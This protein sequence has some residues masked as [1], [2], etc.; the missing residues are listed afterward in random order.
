MQVF[1]HEIDLGIEDLVKANFVS[2]ASSITQSVEKTDEVKEFIQSIASEK[3]PDLMYRNAILASTGWNKNDDV[4]DPIEMLKA[5]N[6]P[7]DKQV[8]FMH[9]E[10][11]IIGH[12]TNAFILNTSE[13]KNFFCPT[14][15]SNILGYTRSSP[16]IAKCN[17]GHEINLDLCIEAGN[18]FDIGVGFVLYKEWSSAERK[19]LISNILEQIDS[20]KWFVSM[21][22]RFPGFDYALID[23]KGNHS[24]VKRDAKSAFLSKYLR[25]YGGPGEYQGRRIGRI[26]RDFHFSGK[27][28]VDNPA[29]ERSIIFG[30]KPEN[31]TSTAILNIGE[32]DMNLEDK[33]K[34]LTSK[35]ESYE[36]QIANL[37]NSNKSIAELKDSNAKELEQ[38]KAEYKTLQDRLTEVEKVLASKVDNLSKAE[39]ENS[40]LKVKLDETEAKVKELNDSIVKAKRIG[41]LTL[42]G[43]SVEDA[44]KTFAKWSALS[45]EQFA[46][47]VT[48]HK[49]TAKKVEEKE[50]SKEDK[51]EDKTE[52]AKCGEA[53]FS[54]AEP[55]KTVASVKLDSETKNDISALSEA[56]M[57]V[58][59]FASKAK[60]QASKTK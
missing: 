32:T 16:S 34:E 3:Q 49:Q 28:I 42:A 24:V 45:D 1:Q 31:F 11:D 8:N 46:D 53:D 57:N 5:K 39:D 26:L 33:V 19:A 60:E 55:E 2:F 22:C 9:N 50:K 18:T 21:E 36:A 35:V 56:L 47:I 20:G 23:S 51:K 14:C 29:N 48:L 59:P 58:L 38:S 30:E 7:V 54:K 52:M 12:M 17:N 25:I 4:F 13:D 6:T 41:E 10:M 37:T 15:Y 40:K 43:L 44:E 27:G